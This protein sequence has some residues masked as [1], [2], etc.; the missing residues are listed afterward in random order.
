MYL[1]IPLGLKKLRKV[2]LQPLVDKVAN[3]LPSWKANLLNRAGR[4]VLIKSTLSAIPTHIA[5]AINI[6]PW[7]IKCIDKCRRN[8]LWRGADT[9]KG[10]HCLLAWPRVCRLPDLGGLGI[11]DLQL[12]GYALRMRWLWLRRTDD[13]RSWLHLPDVT[14]RPVEQLF[15]A[16][17]F[18]E[19]GDGNKALFWTDRWVQGKSLLDIAPC[20][21]NAVGSTIKKQRTVA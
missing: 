17:I 4:T 2:E 14:E 21:C 9:A 16:S 7:V 8:F 12:F 15:S 18:I 10:G 19:L 3:R 20:L 13:T 1:G 11:I 6:S 5:L